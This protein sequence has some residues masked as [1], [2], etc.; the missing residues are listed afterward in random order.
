MYALVLPIYL[1]GIIVIL[2]IRIGWAAII[3]II[4]IILA[5]FLIVKVS[6]NNGFILNQINKYKDQRVQTTSEMI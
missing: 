1:L 2:S 4:V 5:M 3:G 6:K